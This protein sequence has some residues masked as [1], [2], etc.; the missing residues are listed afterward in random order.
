[1]S[2][3]HYPAPAY[4]YR[5]QLRPR[6]I[7]SGF[8]LFLCLVLAMGLTDLFAAADTPTEPQLRPLAARGSV[9]VLKDRIADYPE[10]P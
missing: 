6:D 3:S 5:L 8:A 7:L 2:H 9:L 4:A 1:M 10:M